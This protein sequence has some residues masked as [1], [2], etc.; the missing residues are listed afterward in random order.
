[1]EGT[2]EVVAREAHERRYCPDFILSGDITKGPCKLHL[3][4]LVL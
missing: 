1:V 2:R 4:K 3:T